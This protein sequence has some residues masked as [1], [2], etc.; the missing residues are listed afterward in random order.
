MVKQ[1]DPVSDFPEREMMMTSP[2][3][4]DD[5]AFWEFMAPLLFSTS[6]LEGTYEEV[7]GLAELL[8]LPES[9]R[10]LDLCCGPGRHALELTRR[11]FRVTGVDRTPSY[12]DEARSRA[13]TEGLDVEFVQADMREFRRE[14]AFDGAGSM[15]TSFGFFSDPEDDRRV[16]RH[17]HASLKPGG[18]LVMD[19]VGKEPLARDFLARD[20]QETEGVLVLRESRILD[21]WSKVE[22]RYIVVVDGR[23][24]ERTFLIRVHS[25]AELTEILEECGFG[26]VEVF[27]SLDGSAYDH[28]AER[29]IVRAHRPGRGT[30]V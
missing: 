26:R 12:L 17:L 3:W 20:W 4:H 19:L 13:V 6:R 8:G 24:R 10:V 14:G 7:D 1:A 9:A 21:D 28:Q 5:D 23:L 18:I 15:F 25:A 11:G 16:L 27:G 22:S 29:L 30:G 2:V